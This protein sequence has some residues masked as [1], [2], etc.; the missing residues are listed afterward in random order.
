MA[1]KNTAAFGLYKNR[2]QA[3]SA[4]D[5]PKRGGFPQ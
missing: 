3:E 5:S 2:S 1:G 4:V